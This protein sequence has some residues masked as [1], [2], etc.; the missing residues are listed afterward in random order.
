MKY[1]AIQI[2][3]LLDEQA[4]MGVLKR[5]NLLA[6]GQTSFGIKEVSTSLKWARVPVS[7]IHR[8]TDALEQH[9]L[10]REPAA[11]PPRKP[12][13]LAHMMNKGRKR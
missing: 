6:T 10:I 3:E 1:A 8:F 11:V 13:N 12:A 5:V 7:E 2:P 9:G 4:I